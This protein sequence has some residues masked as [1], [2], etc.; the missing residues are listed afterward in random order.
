MK[1]KLIY[2]TFFLSIF[3]TGFLFYRRSDNQH[4]TTMYV[5]QDIPSQI[6]IKSL[7]INL[8]VY[9][10]I[11]RQNLSK[12]T[13]YKYY[14]NNLVI[15][16]HNM[17]YSKILFTNLHKIK[18]NDKV[19]IK[20]KNSTQVYKVKYSIISTSHKYIQNEKK[21][22]LTLYTCT[23][24]INSNKRFIVKAYPIRKDFTNK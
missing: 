20:M 11:N 24:K 5:E 12:G 4:T 6:V 21:S 16:G 13:I 3:I 8:P 15:F 9:S 22:C 7:H 10:K 1:H 17:I 2:L 14:G 18:P 19:T 23:N